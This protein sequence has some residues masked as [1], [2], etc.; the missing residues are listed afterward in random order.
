MYPDLARRAS[1]YG[2][3]TDVFDLVIK[4]GGEFFYTMPNHPSDGKAQMFREPIVDALSGWRFVNSTDQ[5]INLK[6]NVLFEFSGTVSDLSDNKVQNLI[7]FGKNDI[8]I[9]VTASKIVLK[10]RS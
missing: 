10:I 6:L 4:P 9:K 1:A 5:A 8:T 3:Y 7:I 2:D